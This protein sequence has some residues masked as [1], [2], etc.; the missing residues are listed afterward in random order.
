ME[1][2]RQRELETAQK[3]TAEAE[4]RRKAETQRADDQ[5]RSAQNLR[6]RNQWLAA[7]L[8]LPCSP[9][10]WPSGLASRAAKT[11]QWRILPRYRPKN[12][13]PRPTRT[14]NWQTGVWQRRKM[15]KVVPSTAAR[16]AGSGELANVGRIPGG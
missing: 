16:L 13:K 11:R 5:A 4:A 1:A 10:S 14:P 8:L 12:K 7:A 2:A 6:R 9:A 3:L 15:H